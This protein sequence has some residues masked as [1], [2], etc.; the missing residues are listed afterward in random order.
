MDG[1]FSGWRL[2]AALLRGTW[3]DYWVES[4]MWSRSVHS[5][6]R[7]PTA[8]GLHPE[9]CGQQEKGGDSVPLCSGETPPGPLSPALGLLL[10]EWHEPAG[11]IP[12]EGHGEDRRVGVPPLWGKAESWCCSAWRR[13]QRD[14][15][16][17]LQYLKGACK[18]DHFLAVIGQRIILVK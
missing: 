15:I 6:P 3:G 5:Q 8:R 4:W 18:K 2:R 11:S 17:T 16:A 12:G 13:L 14:L 1:L 7:K 9:Q 10:Q